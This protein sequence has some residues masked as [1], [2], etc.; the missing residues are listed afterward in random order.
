LTTAPA[1]RSASSPA[2]LPARFLSGQ[3]AIIVFIQFCESPH[4]FLHFFTRDHPIIIGI[5]RGE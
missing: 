4:C 1:H 2:C 3:L 5:D